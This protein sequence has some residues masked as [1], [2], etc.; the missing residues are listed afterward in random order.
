MVLFP[1]G[2]AGRSESAL[3]AVSTELLFE[4][5]TVIE[6]ESVPPVPNFEGGLNLHSIHRIIAAAIP[7]AGTGSRAFQ[8]YFAMNY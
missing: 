6:T 4:G 1:C 8:I 2:Y 7:R 3:E 5:D